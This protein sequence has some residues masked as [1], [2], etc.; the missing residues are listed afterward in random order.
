MII[1]Q[2]AATLPA[3][4]T[5]ETSRMDAIEAIMTV[6]GA[7]DDLD[8]PAMVVTTKTITDEE[9]QAH[10]DDLT[11]KSSLTSL[12]D[13]VLTS[14]TFKSFYNQM[15]TASLLSGWSKLSSPKVCDVRLCTCVR[16]FLRTRL[17]NDK[18]L[19]VST[20]SLTWIFGHKRWA[21]FQYRHLIAQQGPTTFGMIST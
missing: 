16:T 15:L 6:V 17:F 3:T 12:G 21:R 19:K 14:L 1:D 7:V 5:E 20:L 10:M 11:M 18:Q 9:A 8:P 2:V 4:T 13:M